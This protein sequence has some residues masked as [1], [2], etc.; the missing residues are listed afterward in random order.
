[1]KKSKKFLKNF[2]IRMGLNERSEKIWFWC[3]FLLLLLYTEFIV[4]GQE[5][6]HKI[7]SI[8]F[9]VF[10]AVCVIPLCFA[11]VILCNRVK[12]ILCINREDNQKFKGRI[13]IFTGIFL[14]TFAI[15][16]I[17][18]LAFWPGSFSYDSINQYS[19]VVNNSYN[20]WHPVL[21][22]WLFFLLPIKLF[23]NPAAIIIMQLIWFSLA[24]A[25]LYYV[26]YENSCPKYFMLIS[27]LYIAANSNTAQI[28]LYPWKDS[29]FSIFS[30]IL[31]THLIR[32]YATDGKW[33][34]KWYHMLI[35]SANAFLAL[36]MRHN[37]V[38]LVAPVFLILLLFLKNIRK[39]IIV[40]VV[41][42]TVAASLLNGPVFNFVGVGHPGGRVTETV[43]FPMTILSNIYVHDRGALSEEGKKFMDALA[44]KEEWEN[45]YVTGSFNSIK[46]G[47]SLD[48]GGKIETEG[49][50][51]IIKYMIE[52]SVKR[53]DLAWDAFVNLT[54]IVWGVIGGN[55]AVIW[56]SMAANEYGIY[57]CGSNFLNKI[58]SFYGSAS[59]FL[60][61]KYLYNFTGTVILFL[62]LMAVGKLDK[63]NLAK[64]FMVLAP[65][66]YNF[67][68]MLLLSGSDFRFFHFNFLIVVPLLYIIL[69]R[70]RECDD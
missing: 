12:N 55:G 52:A 59:H 22:T 42:V 36:E 69:M 11:G 4:F 61:I 46:W 64:V 23:N 39:N 35:F 30:L 43:G 49:R 5:T 38:L 53:P 29:A 37:A 26:L 7:S 31:F 32:I 57:Y 27:Y 54:W 51:K 8:F 58:L 13:M 10:F 44:T 6:T 56:H 67:G 1:M 16:F 40:A 70:K 33:L 63:K 14:L 9:I 66:V 15:F 41:L 50:G 25:Y 17:W 19:Q 21:H 2:Q 24:V 68:T 47:S 65:M 62:L 45:N 60:P 3:G 48:I 34:K 20:N 28:M 18:Q